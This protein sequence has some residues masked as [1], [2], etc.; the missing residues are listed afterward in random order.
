MTDEK[1]SSG[2][3]SLVPRLLGE[4]LVIIAGVLIALA[5]DRWNQARLERSAAADYL[6]QLAGEIRQD[7]TTV[8]DFF[9]T[10]PGAEA[11]RDSLFAAVN[12]SRALQAGDGSLLFRA[13]GLFVFPPVVA[14]NELH[15]TGSLGL[16]KDKELR[17]EL[18][19]YYATRARN[20]AVIQRIESRSRD[21]YFDALYPLGIMDGSIESEELAEF[22]ALPEATNLL[23]GLG[24]YRSGLHAYL[25]RLLVRANRVLSALEA[26]GGAGSE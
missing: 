8:A 13:A 14:W 7:S 24:G 20:E 25:S 17:R 12:G 21:P 10:T 26:G 2:G 11:A 22:I 23:R 3:A 5:A 1:T 9:A 15:N 6:V 4:L 16:I 19:G 18:S